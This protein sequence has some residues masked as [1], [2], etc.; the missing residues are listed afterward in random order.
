[1][2]LGKARH[3]NRSEPDKVTTSSKK[4]NSSANEDDEKIAKRLKKQLKDFNLAG[5]AIAILTVSRKM[6]GSA[7]AP[8]RDAALLKVM[9]DVK[10][11]RFMSAPDE[12]WMRAHTASAF[13]D[14]VWNGQFEE[15][16]KDPEGGLATNSSEHHKV[17]AFHVLAEVFCWYWAVE[18]GRGASEK[19][20]LCPDSLFQAITNE[21][22]T[23]ARLWSTSTGMFLG[24]KPSPIGYKAGTQSMKPANVQPG[25]AAQTDKTGSGL[26]RPTFVPRLRQ[27]PCSYC[28]VMRRV[29]DLSHQEKTCPFWLAEQR[30]RAATGNASTAATPTP[31]ATGGQTAPGS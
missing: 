31:G 26:P 17:S 16:L 10:A 20:T 22:P 6:I 23:A 21:A 28:R 27:S 15:F 7:T 11:G 5:P 18:S 2:V 1:M 25:T 13:A 29:V 14:P 4:R 19:A 24:G 30:K 9:Q 8:K 12:Q 3:R